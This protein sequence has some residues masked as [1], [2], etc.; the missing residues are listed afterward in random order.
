LLLTGRDISV[1]A[2]GIAKD[3]SAGYAVA[4][5]FECPLFVPVAKA[6]EHLTKGRAGEGNRPWSAGAGVAVLASGLDF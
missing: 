2:E 4:L 5:G 6:P 3:L 1:F